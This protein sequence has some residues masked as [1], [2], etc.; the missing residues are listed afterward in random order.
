MI[1]LNQYHQ[2]VLAGTVT[3]GLQSQCFSGKVGGVHATFLWEVLSSHLRG[4]NIAKT[5]VFHCSERMSFLFV[6]EPKICICWFAAKF[7]PRCEHCRVHG[8][9]RFSSGL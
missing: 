3:P 8:Q 7:A 4:T 1:P 6:L 9:D 5:C 2:L